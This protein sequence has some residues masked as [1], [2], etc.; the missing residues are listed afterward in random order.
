MHARPAVPQSHT[1][2]V[3][4][5][6]QKA[7]MAVADVATEAGAAVVARG[8]IGT[9]QCDRDARIRTRHAKRTPLGFRAAAGPWR[10][11]LARALA[12]N[13]H[14][15]WGVAPSRVPQTA[16]DRVT[17]ER[18]G[19]VPWARLMPSGARTPGSVPRGE[20]DAL[21]AR[22]RARDA[23][24][25]A[26]TPA[27][28]RRNACPLRRDRREAG[29]APRRPAH[30]RWRA[31]VGWPTPA[32]QRVSRA[33]G[34]AVTAPTERLRRREPERHAQ[35]TTGRLAPAG[36]A[37]RALRGVPC[38]VAVASGAELGELPRVTPPRQLRHDLGLTPSASASGARRRQG[39]ITNTGTRHARRALVEGARAARSPATVSRHLQRRREKRPHGSQDS[40]WQAPVRVC[41]R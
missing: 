38:P 37:L 35:V 32:P 8:T 31:A 30:R 24:L 41:Q 25:R 2:S 10:Y 12:K 20:G 18:R 40:G 14:V 29:Q 28:C 16:G 33:Y 5:D 36:E 39:G 27:T 4:M 26:C 17:P 22:T 1:L 7:S 23:A 9:R 21:R 34:R 15:C 13:G 19:A 3:G 6:V 11:W